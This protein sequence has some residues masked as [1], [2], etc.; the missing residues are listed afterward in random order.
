VSGGNRSYFLS[1][2]GYTWGRYY[3]EAAGTF[4]TEDQ[5]GFGCFSGAVTDY[6]LSLVVFHLAVA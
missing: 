4:M 6:G 2:D 3:Q 1:Q 5:Y